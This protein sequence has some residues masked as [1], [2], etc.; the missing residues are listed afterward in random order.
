MNANRKAY[1]KIKRFNDFAGLLG[2]VIRETDYIESCC[3]TY[4]DTGNYLDY[5]INKY[6]ESFDVIEQTVIAICGHGFESLLNL[7]REN[8]EY[9][10]S[11]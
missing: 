6:P 4:E 9:Y 7:V 5:V 1:N 3:D 2:F 8:R 11:L 10:E